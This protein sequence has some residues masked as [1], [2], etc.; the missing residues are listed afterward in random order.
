MKIQN[1]NNIINKSLHQEVKNRILLESKG[2]DYYHVMKDGEPIETF[3]SYEEAEQYVMDNKDGEKKLLIDKVRYESY[4]HMIDSLDEMSEKVDLKNKNMKKNKI[5]EQLENLDFEMH[6]YD[7]ESSDMPN[8]LMSDDFDER[9]LNKYLES[10]I[11]D[12][13]SNKMSYDENFEEYL[14]NEGYDLDEDLYELDLG[15]DMSYDEISDDYQSQENYDMTEDDLY[16]EGNVCNECGSRLNEDGSCDECTGKMYEEIYE[17][18]SMCSECGTMLNEDGSCDECAGAMYESKKILHKNELIARIRKIVAESIP[19]K[20]AAEK[21]RK[22]SGKENKSYYDE[23]GKKMKNYLSFQGNDNPEF[24]H[25]IGASQK[26]AARINSPKENDEIN[27]NYA[28]LESLQYDT[29]PSENFKKRMKMAIEGD[30]MM[31]NGT[32]TKKAEIKPSNGAPKGNEAKEKLGNQIKTKETTKKLN[33]RKES[34]PKKSERV[35]YK[36]E[37]V[38]VDTSKKSNLNE[39]HIINEIE[40]MKNLYK[41]NDKTQ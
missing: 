41:Y 37:K 28:G 7:T 1:I 5:N 38:P 25:Q 6:E 26:K 8:K 39:N 19:G 24:P 40:R 16:E 32:Y 15:E 23:V 21:S 31:G 30:S 12:K 3:E 2:K 11:D 36:K 35:I 14:P 29:E 13:S 27:K 22:D 20:K 34:R 17:T 4:E 18:E 9:I 33:Q 10:G